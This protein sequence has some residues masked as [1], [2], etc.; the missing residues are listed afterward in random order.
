MPGPLPFRVFLASPG[1]LE[2]E[3]E[4]VRGCVNEL[5]TTARRQSVTFELVGWEQV[6]GTARRPQEAINELISECHFLI[7]LFKDH[8]GS[9]PGSPWGFTSGTEE[10]LFTALLHLGDAERPMRDVWVAF[11]EHS[12]PRKK[13]ISSLRAQMNSRH[14]LL[15][16]TV[17]SPNDLKAKLAERLQGWAQIRGRKVERHVDLLPSSGRDVLGAS[18]R[19][20]RG[21]KLVALGQAEA[22]LRVLAEAAAIGGP[23]EQLAYAQQLARVGD[24][25]GALRATDEAIDFFVKGQAPLGTPLCAEAFAAKADLLRRQGSFARAIA[26]LEHALT[27]LDPAD[28]G[29]VSVHCRTLDALGL[30]RQKTGDY[31]GARASFQ[32]ALESRTAAALEADQCQSRINLARLALAE[33]DVDSAHDHS[34]WASEHLRH[35]PSSALHANAAVLAAQ[36]DLRRLLPGD[37]AAK[38]RSALEINRM[39]DNRRGEAIALNILAQC[40]L[41]ERQFA[42]A[43]EHAQASLQL[44]VAINDD[45]GADQAR[46][47]LLQCEPPTQGNPP[48]SSPYSSI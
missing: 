23:V 42:A 40:E 27:L 25:D 18:A 39:I 26:L 48:T 45:F 19:R 38:A 5:N 7:A 44:N 30:T 4:V 36:I 17:A 1:G 47:L 29:A 2:A 3:R 35:F 16:E 22:G 14:S 11:I 10:E 9:E 41:H 13:E 15:Y 33:G 8:W 24:M 34:A 6:R 43:R 31:P 32:E 20:V 28:L 12:L 21:K 37:G 46:A